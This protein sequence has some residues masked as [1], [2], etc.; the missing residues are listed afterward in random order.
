MDALLLP[1]V[2]FAISGSG[3]AFQGFA[4]LPGMYFVMGSIIHGLAIF[5]NYHLGRLVYHAQR[6]CDMIG[7]VA[8]VDQIQVI[9]IKVPDRKVPTFHELMQGH[10]TDPAADAVLEQ[11]YGFVMGVCH[12]TFPLI[13]GTQHFPIRVNV[14]VVCMEQIIY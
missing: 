14:G 9:K 5:N 8:V 10:G 2:H 13:E 4:Q 3:Y 6:L 1:F 11:H 7:N 12:Q